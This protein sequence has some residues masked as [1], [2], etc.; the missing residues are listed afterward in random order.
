[1]FVKEVRP[2]FIKDS[3]REKTIS[4]TLHTYHG[5]F[6]ASAP[7][8]KSTGAHEVGA[9]SKKGK[10]HSMKNLRHFCR[11]IKS[12]NFFIRKLEDLKKLKDLIERFER[13][14]G[15]LGGNITYVLE[16]VFLKAAAAEE[17]KELWRLI[18][19]STDL[20]KKS[21]MPMPIGNCIGGGLHTTGIRGKKPD[22]QEFLLIPKE[23]SFRHATTVNIRA[24]EYARK[25]LKSKKK[26]DE[27]AWNTKKTNEETLEILKK[28][29]EKY[30]LRIGLDIAASSFFQRN[31]YEYKNKSLT[32]DRLDQIDYI[33]RL[34]R[35]FG[36]FYVEDPMDE[37]DFLGFKQIL[38][39]TKDYRTKS[40]IVGD[41]LT[42]TNVGRLSRA[43]RSKSINAIIVK[44]NQIGSLLEVAKV[45]KLAKKHGLKI[46]F[47]HRSGETMDPALADYAV[48]FG[49]DFIKMGIMGKERLI[50]HKR[51]IDIERSLN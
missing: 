36:I 7:S 33:E 47:S 41:D 27:S 19:D 18:R 28:V 3:R 5:T 24:Y 20:E 38:S 42:T 50:K 43:I 34:I 14:F 46:I 29:A 45:V 4:I 22:F 39:T 35:K 12:K 26:T 16:S 6:T 44:P 13:R 25:L 11:L 31:Y 15:L 2:R 30:K 10:A 32:R 51:L 1:M 40:L 23:K 8:G 9:Y 48:G 49:A 37:E 21:K 17:N